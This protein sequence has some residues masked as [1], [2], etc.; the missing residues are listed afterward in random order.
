MNEHELAKVDLPYEKVK[1]IVNEIDERIFFFQ[2][3]ID[4][5]EEEGER[6]LFLIASTY[7]FLKVRE[8]L[9]C[10]SH[11]TRLQQF[12]TFG[13]NPKRTPK[14]IIALLIVILMAILLGGNS[15]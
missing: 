1:Q 6:K 5:E 15:P 4:E 14:Y 8:A 10:A 11:K 7:G 9:I 12:T 3:K 13:G 2:R